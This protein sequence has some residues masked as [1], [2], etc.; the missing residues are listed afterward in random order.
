MSNP[1]RPLLP[2]IAICIGGT[3]GYNHDALG[4]N[5]GA[6]TPKSTLEVATNANQGS[7]FRA[8]RESPNG[9]LLDL[10][11]SAEEEFASLWMT[12]SGRAWLRTHPKALIDLT[13]VQVSNLLLATARDGDEAVAQ[14]CSALPGEKCVNAL[15]GY[16]GGLL[17]TDP[18]KV[19]RQSL[20]TAGKDGATFLTQRCAGAIVRTFP[21]ALKGLIEKIPPP[22]RSLVL[23]EVIGDLAVD[24]G[25]DFATSFDRTLFDENSE[26]AQLATRRIVSS[27]IFSNDLK[28]EID[29]WFTSLSNP[30]LKQYAQ[31]FYARESVRLSGL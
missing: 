9:S 6:G 18:M 13:R 1:F 12:S 8:F 17:L 11:S 16:W 23:K 25:I 26:N 4:D 29:A 28:S 5:S 20:L 24:E 7:P 2:I 21:G 19:W 30:D 10:G 31:D 14:L 3:I 27:A 22:T 15:K